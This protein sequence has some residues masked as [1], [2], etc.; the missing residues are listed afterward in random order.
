LITFIIDSVS[1]LIYVEDE[2]IYDVVLCLKYLI[3]IEEES[4][5]LIEKLNL[6][7]EADIF[8]KIVDLIFTKEKSSHGLL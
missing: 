2:A 7:S 8:R 3:E 1:Q 4:H 5:I 6:I